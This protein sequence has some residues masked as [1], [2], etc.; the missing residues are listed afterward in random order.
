MLAS[1]AKLA[2]NNLDCISVYLNALR[3][4]RENGGYG[5]VETKVKD[6]LVLVVRAIVEF[7][8]DRT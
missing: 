4:V 5:S 1:E 7:H 2:E 6:G 3:I 8:I